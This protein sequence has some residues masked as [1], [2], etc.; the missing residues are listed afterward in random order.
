VSIPPE[1]LESWAFYD[2]SVLKETHLCRFVGKDTVW[3]LK[4]AYACHSGFHQLKR[5]TAFSAT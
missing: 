4:K 5:T 2:L 3:K 1:Q